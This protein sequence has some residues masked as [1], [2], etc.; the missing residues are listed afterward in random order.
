[1]KHSPLEQ[2]I[3]Y[4]TLLCFITGAW[5]TSFIIVIEIGRYL[6]YPTY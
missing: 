3:I 5:C 4:L 2:L 6:G 1:M